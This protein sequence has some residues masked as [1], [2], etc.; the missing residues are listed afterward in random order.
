MEFPGVV[1]AYVFY[2]FYKPVF[3]RQRNGS[4]IPSIPG[5]LIFLKSQVSTFRTCIGTA[6]WVLELSAGFRR[7]VGLARIDHG[8]ILKLY[9][10]NNA[11]F[12]LDEWVGSEKC[13]L[14]RLIL[15]AVHWFGLQSR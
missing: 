14:E 7:R 11:S 12:A 6:C 9:A 4:S 15:V 3:I 5:L 8:R 1:R 10:Q 2:N 13:V